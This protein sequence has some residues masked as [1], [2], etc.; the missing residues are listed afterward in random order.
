MQ[1]E[2]QNTFHDTRNFDFH[3]IQKKSI[4]RVISLNPEKRGRLDQGKWHLE[5]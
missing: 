5:L 2:D 3:R 1:P 4:P